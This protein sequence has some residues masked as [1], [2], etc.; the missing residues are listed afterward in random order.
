[1]SKLKKFGIDTSLNALN[2]FDTDLGLIP[3]LQRID[4]DWEVCEHPHKQYLLS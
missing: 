3:L 1:M 2:S 4:I